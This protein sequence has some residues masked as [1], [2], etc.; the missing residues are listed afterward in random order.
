[1]T[2]DP[3]SALG[4]TPPC[5]CWLTAQAVPRLR[6]G[7]DLFN[8]ASDWAD[9]CGLLPPGGSVNGGGVSDEFFDLALLV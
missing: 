5:A 4:V 2:F 9:S 8:V 6:P 1:M 7:M 3:S